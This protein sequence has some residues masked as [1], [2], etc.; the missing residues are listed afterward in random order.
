MEEQQMSEKKV[1]N[2]NI[3]I[4]LGLVCIVLLSGLIVVIAMGIGGTSDSQTI[5]SLQAQITNKDTTI[6]SLNSQIT[7]LQTSLNSQNNIA[8]D[9]STEIDQLTAEIEYYYSVSHLN[10]SDVM[11]NSQSFTQDPSANTVIWQDAVNY[12][13][14]VTVTAQ[15]S[16]NTTYIQTVYTYNGVNYNQNITV[17]T[18]GTAYFPVLP[19][20][21]EISLGNIESTNSNTGTVSAIYYY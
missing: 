6:A 1:V 7:S 12:A 9:N 10:E 19:G 16:S 15:A 11:V 8:V 14:Y 17:G 2:R 21:L 5:S 4:A 18:S 20:L 3:A 13:G